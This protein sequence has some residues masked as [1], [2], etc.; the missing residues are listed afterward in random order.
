LH[1][2]CITIED[3]RIE[4]R[5]AKKRESRNALLCLLLFIAGIGPKL[6]EE[7]SMLPCGPSI[8]IVGSTWITGW[9]G[10]EL[11]SSCRPADSK[12]RR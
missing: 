5:A 10:G 1:L 6:A 3:D 4:N 7:G 9:G 11:N 8:G 12:C 2:F